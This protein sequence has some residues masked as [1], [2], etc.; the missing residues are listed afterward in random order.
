[1]KKAKVT[2]AP[3]AVKIEAKEKAEFL[4]FYNKA[5]KEKE[6]PLIRVADA[7][8]GVVGCEVELESIMKWDKDAQKAV[9]SYIKITIKKPV[10]GEFVA[11]KELL[12]GHNDEKNTKWVMVVKPEVQAQKQT[13]I[14]C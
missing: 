8:T 4:S 5:A 2:S 6:T 1:M 11:V 13:A 10:D 7:V 14:S 3:V 12:I 9:F